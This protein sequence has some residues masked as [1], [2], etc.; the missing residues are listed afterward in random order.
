[1]KTSFGTKPLDAAARP[2]ESAGRLD[3]GQMRSFLQIIASEIEPR[4]RADGSWFVDHLYAS[5]VGSDHVERGHT[6]SA[7]SADAAIREAFAQ[8]TEGQPRLRLPAGTEAQWNGNG[9][10][11]LEGSLETLR[12]KTYEVVHG[13]PMPSSKVYTGQVAT[14]EQRP[15]LPVIEKYPSAKS[16]L[17]SARLL[18]KGFGLD[19]AGKPKEALAQYD[20]AR[21]ALRGEIAAALV[22]KLT[23]QNM[24]AGQLAAMPAHADPLIAGFLS[25]SGLFAQL[26]T[27]IQESFLKL[28]NRS[29]L[30]MKHDG[31]PGAACALLMTALTLN[32]TYGPALYNL[33]CATL[34]I[35]L[36]ADRAD[37]PARNREALGYLEQALASDKKF[38]T[39]LALKDPDWNPVRQDPTFRRLAGLD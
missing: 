10:N 1:M 35:E 14:K 32:P 21:A 2:P 30:A 11:V 20:L 27:A 37:I 8:L 18:D 12:A 15:T 28:E 16:S 39:S 38:F 19:Q 3:V 29:G 33:A 26:P 9:W 5:V 17:E 34:A 31:D 23:S 25:R 7:T 22:D 36:P 13:E 24:S 4:Q 6:Q